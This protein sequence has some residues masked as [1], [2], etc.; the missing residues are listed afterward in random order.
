MFAREGYN[1]FLG[2]SNW[3]EWFPRLSIVRGIINIMIYSDK[4]FSHSDWQ[5]GW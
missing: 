4:S 3:V 2:C 1:T 5:S